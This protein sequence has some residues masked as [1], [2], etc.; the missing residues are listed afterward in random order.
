MDD[1]FGQDENPMDKALKKVADAMAVSVEE[2]RYI[3]DS[4]GPI[5]AGEIVKCVLIDRETERVIEEAA[6]TKEYWWRRKPSWPL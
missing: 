2:A 3:F 5:N 4:V 1:I 6:R